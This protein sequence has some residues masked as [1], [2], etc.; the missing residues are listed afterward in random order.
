[1]LSHFVLNF[2]MWYIPHG[3]TWSMDDLQIKAALT[4]AAVLMPPSS[5]C[6]K[7]A[8]VTVELMEDIFHKLNLS[9]PLD[10]AVASCF[11]MTFYSVLCTREFTVPA[12]NAFD[13]ALRVKPS[14]V[15]NRR[16]H[17]DLEVTL[18]Q[19]GVTDPKAALENHLSQ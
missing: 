17:N 5:K 13:P 10:V 14:D 6:S 2:L 4:G 1:M 15:S 7:R 8:P 12:L 9:D 11:S 19:E 3:V 18:C 16:D